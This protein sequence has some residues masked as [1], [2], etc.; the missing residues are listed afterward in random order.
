MGLSVSVGQLA[1]SLAQGYEEETAAARA[2]VREVNRIL[3][4]HGLPPHVEPEVLPPFHDRCA[5]VGMP[6]S[7]LHYLRRAIAYARQAPDEFAPATDANP[8]RDPRVEDELFSYFDSHLICHSDCGGFYVPIDFP[9]PLYGEHDTLGSCQAAMREL[10]L[11]APLLGIRL[12]ADGTLSDAEAEAINKSDRD[13][14]PLR[15]ERYVW[16]KLFER[17]RHSIATGALVTFG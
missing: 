8:A 4:E 16:L 7:M 11:V 17:F 1:W 9:E 2:D 13:G 3:A 6:Y 12:N 15:T 10:V 5:G 14:Q